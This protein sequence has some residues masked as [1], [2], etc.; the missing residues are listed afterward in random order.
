MIFIL[1]KKRKDTISNKGQRSITDCFAITKKARRSPTP[2]VK[3]TESSSEEDIDHITITRPKKI[4]SAI[5]T[6]KHTSSSNK[7]YDDDHT[8]FT[9]KVRSSPFKHA[10]SSKQMFD[11]EH[12]S[13]T[14][15]ARSSPSKHSGSSSE[16]CD[17]IVID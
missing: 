1:G 9:P 12:T 3:H 2:P 13:F 5:A 16:D 10:S 4:R 6:G 11:I 14:K 17:V 15:K 7:I 8:A